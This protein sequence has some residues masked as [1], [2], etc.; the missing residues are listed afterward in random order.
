MI[1]LCRGQANNLALKIL[2]ASTPFYVTQRDRI[3][4][5]C[6]SRPR[7][8]APETGEREPISDAGEKATTVGLLWRL[9]C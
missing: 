3:V 9:N 2:N 7:G 8:H 5:W 4:G 1:A 6:T